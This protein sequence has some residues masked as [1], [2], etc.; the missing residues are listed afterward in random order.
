MYKLQYLRS[1]TRI[2]VTLMQPGW[3]GLLQT[4]KTHSWHAFKFPARWEVG[5]LSKEDYVLVQHQP[6]T[7][8]RAASPP[9]ST[10][11]MAVGCNPFD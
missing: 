5:E 3:L 2:M 1:A 4:I 9:W 11:A 7:T 10:V 6:I 8:S